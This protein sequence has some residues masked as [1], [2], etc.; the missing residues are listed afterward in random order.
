MRLKE[1][2]MTDCAECVAG[3]VFNC[4]CFNDTSKTAGA[5]VIARL[6][7]LENNGQLDSSTSN[8]II[9]NVVAY[10]YTVATLTCQ[11]A[12][13]NQEVLD[14]QCTNEDLGR[15]VRTNPNC[16]KCMQL[17]AEVAADRKKLE[18]DA[19]AINPNYKQQVVLSPVEQAYFGLEQDH[20]DGICKYV[21]FQCIIEN[22]SQNIQMQLVESCDTN[23]QTFISAF[24]Q[25]M[26][27]QAAV[28]LSQH[29]SAL[30][31]TGLAIQKQEDIT[32][33]AFEMASTIRQMTTVKMISAMKMNAF[34]LQNMTIEKDSTSVMVQNGTQ[35]I[36]TSMFASIVSRAYNNTAVQTSIDFQSKQQEIQ[37]E[38]TFTDLVNSLQTTVDTIE[39][40]MINTIGKIM[41]TLIALLLVLLFIFA[42]LFFFK[43]DFLFGG[44]ITNDD[45]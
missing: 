23:T 38:T 27:V 26:S 43:P 5:D 33:L 28:E 7:A 20:S 6:F 42:A 32:S 9:A 36:T 16:I 30:Q 15:K 45:S 14:V 19:H 3:S 1:S 40:L 18:D 24:V 29:V 44:T 21:C 25:G 34:N 31:S 12:F 8:G 39:T 41:V 13:V 22:L 4:Q 17:A 37:I 2:R 11:Q 35:G 10:G